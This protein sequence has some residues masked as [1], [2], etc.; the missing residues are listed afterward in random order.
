MA[1]ASVPNPAFNDPVLNRLFLSPEEKASKEKGKAIVK[2][3]YKNQTNSDTNLSFF[4]ARNA[5]WIML[6]LWAKGSQ[7]MNEFL[8]YMSV[9]DGNK[10]WVNIDLT[11]T[12]IAA[13]FVGTLVESMA[14]NKTYPSV[15][16]IDDGSL[17]EKEQRLLDALF[18][19]QEV[20]TINDI[21]QQAGIQLEPTNAY[22]PDDELSAKVYFELEDRLPKEIRFEEYLS[23]IQKEINFD[24][25]VNRKTLYDFIVL[26]CGATKI[27]KVSPKKYTVRKCNP[28]NLIYNFFIND[29]GQCEITQIGEFYN[30]KVRDFRS[31]FGKSDDNPSGLTEREIFNLAKLSSNKNIG[32]FNYMWSDNWAYT[33]YN[34]NRPYD[35]NSILVFDCEVNFEEEEYYVSKKDAY[36][37]EN[38]QGPKKNIPYQQKTKDGKIIEQP[39]P[40]DTEIIRRKKNTWMR[41]VY[42]PYGD[43]MLYWGQT[44]LIITPYTEVAKPMSSYSINI[45]NNDGEYVPSLFERIMEPLREYQ[46]VKLKRKQ[47]ISQV[48]PDGYKIDIESAR[49][50]DLGNG[51]TVPWEELIRIKRQTGVELWSSKGID[52]LSREMPA[53]SAGVHS[54]TISKIL[55]LTNVANGILM[56]IRQLIGVPMYRDGADVGDR[57]SGVLQEQQTISSFNVTDFIQNGN[58]QLW[59]ETFYK[60]C[61]LHW[62]DVVKEEPESKDDMINTRF[63]VS[64]NMKMTEY[65]KQLLEA[66]IQRYSQVP[67]AQGNPSL[68]PKDAMM[69]REI[70][71]SRLARWYM[72]KTYEENR[73]NAIK[74][75]QLLQEQNAKLQQESNEQAAEKAIQLQQDKIAAEKEMK[76]FDSNNKK[77]E[78][79]LEKGL[80]LYKVILTPVVTSGGEGQSP[81]QLPQPTMPPSLQALLDATFQ[82]IAVTLVQDRQMQQAQEAAQQ[83]EQMAM[84]QEEM[85]AQQQMQQPQMQ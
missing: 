31:K 12:R 1:E 24:R 37:R 9:S 40:E 26:N 74:E 61:L 29:N 35:D 6:L 25:I 71:N 68:T 36:G 4:K 62:N 72:V 11:Q 66:D 21:Q 82:S 51:D 54:Q 60:L 30:L 57:T 75:S 73:R 8:D 33:T 19:M 16:A 83:Q 28:T 77:Q 18:R 13:Q 17:S 39:K 63:E 42:A 5:R 76:E 50:I 49:N 55:E 47:L 84:Q 7:T 81:K 59:E 32:I 10:A 23:C 67:D 14:K 46:L 43:T 2:E 53:I 22:V 48:E 27:E 79:L 65:Q 69:L 85:A 58:N 3:I 15:N 56:E 44:D 20:E 38:I 41:G 45:P 80:E 52:P 34:Q 70:D 78:I 64:V